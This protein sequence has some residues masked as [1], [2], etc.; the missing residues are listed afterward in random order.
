MTDRKIARYSIFGIIPLVTLNFDLHDLYHI[1]S[2]L[3]FDTNSIALS[4]AVD[5]RN[6]VMCVNVMFHI[7]C[8]MLKN[9]NF[10]SNFHGNHAQ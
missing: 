1:S 2:H 4:E 3:S 6:L 7:L 10:I 9:A 5:Y 8:V